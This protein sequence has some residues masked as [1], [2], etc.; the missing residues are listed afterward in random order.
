MRFPCASP[1]NRCANPPISNLS[2][3]AADGPT[4]IGFNTG[5]DLVPPLGDSWTDPNGY[6]FCESLV[7]QA[8][9]DLCAQNRQF[10]NQV[11]DCVG[12]GGC[13]RGPTGNP[14]PIFTNQEASFTAFCPD[15]SPFV[16]TVPAGR[17]QA[18]SVIEANRIAASFARVEANLNKVCLGTLASF[19]CLRGSYGSTITVSGRGPFTFSVFSGALPPGLGL[20]VTGSNTVL[21]SGTATAAGNY[22][23]ML[24]A[25]NALGYFMRK[26]YTVSVLGITTASL[27]NF[28]QGQPYSQQL[29]AA[30]GTPPYT[31]TLEAGSLPAGL[32]LSGSGLISGTPTDTTS[33]SFDVGVLDDSGVSVVCETGFVMEANVVSTAFAYYKMDETPSGTRADSVGPNPLKEATLIFFPNDVFSSV[34]II[35]NGADFTGDAGDRS[36]LV[37]DSP[38]AFSFTGS[39]SVSFWIFPRN[40][41]GSEQ[42]L[43]ISGLQIEANVG[44]GQL[45][46][47]PF[48]RTPGPTFVPLS[49]FDMP[50]NAWGHIVL[51]WDATIGQAKVYRNGGL[52]STQSGIAALDTANA[53][54]RVGGSDGGVALNTFAGHADELGWWT[55]VLTQAEVTALYNGGSGLAFGSPGFPP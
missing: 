46:V 45:R 12:G 49:Q 17:Y 2:A 55:R 32:T 42:M 9:A 5:S 14:L 24:M 13:W 21:L 11:D 25:E 37:T 6:A 27:P 34:G 43:T 19:V 41:G 3:E 36:Y 54:M 26:E 28:T 10:I 1:P 35:N 31:F 52:N 48:M 4:F 29:T 7:S 53:F 40:P 44:V 51:T 20:S 33:V 38:T 47:L 30:G 23:F 16:F 22:T 18:L 39:F 8:D 50:Y 15:G